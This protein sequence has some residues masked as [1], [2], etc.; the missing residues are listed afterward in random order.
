MLML[1][2]LENIERK[3]IENDMFCLVRAV[4][5]KSGGRAVLVVPTMDKIFL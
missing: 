5:L 2:W 1:S 4:D 3:L